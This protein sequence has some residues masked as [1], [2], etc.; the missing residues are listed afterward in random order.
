MVKKQKLQRKG[1]VEKKGDVVDSMG[2]IIA[3]ILGLATVLLIQLYKK[4]V[5]KK[6]RKFGIWNWVLSIFV[7]LYVDFLIYWL[8]MGVWEGQPKAGIVGLFLMGII[9]VVI[10][11]VAQLLVSKSFGKKTIAKL[12]KGEK[13]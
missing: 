13:A 11:A 10:V 7:T 2:G 3:Y 4:S 5:E 6:N 9:G 8:Y 12:M 1:K